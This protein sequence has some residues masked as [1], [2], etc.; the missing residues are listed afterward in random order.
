MNWADIIIAFVEVSPLALAILFQVFGDYNQ[1]VRD[2]VT[3]APRL[4]IEGDYDKFEPYAVY[5]YDWFRSRYTTAF[6]LLYV[7]FLLL[8]EFANSVQTDHTNFGFLFF[9]VIFI[10]LSPVSIFYIDHLFSISGEQDP[11]TYFSYYYTSSA[12]ELEEIYASSKLLSVKWIS[13]YTQILLLI[14]SF[15]LSI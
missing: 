4:G 14:I 5:A 3:Q 2:C 15:L 11:H 13:T 12:P 10:L 1:K 8:S 6:S 9:S 7:G